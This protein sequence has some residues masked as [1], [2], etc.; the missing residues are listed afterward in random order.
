MFPPREEWHDWKE[1]DPQAWPRKEERSYHLIPTTCFNCEF[2]CGLLAYVDKES[3]K[4][5]KLEGNPE[6]PGSR[7]GNCA[8]GPATINQINDPERILYPLKRKGKRGGGEWERISWQQ[9]LDE[10]AARLHVPSPKT[11]A[12]KSPA[13]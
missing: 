2:A 8:K 7:G 11:G 13:T 6:H 10:I 4:I 1:Y 12:T 3:G 5:R 9:A